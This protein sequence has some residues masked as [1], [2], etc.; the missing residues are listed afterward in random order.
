M[1]GF[2]GSRGR[3]ESPRI[4][5]DLFSFDERNDS[6]SNIRKRTP[7]KFV[8]HLNDL[9]QCF[10]TVYFTTDNAGA[11]NSVGPEKHSE[12]VPPITGELKHSAFGARGSSIALL[13]GKETWNVSK[14]LLRSP[15]QKGRAS[16]SLLHSSWART[17][18]RRCGPATARRGHILPAVFPP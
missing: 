5:H 6:R 1:P 11:G 7:D 16:G 3:V 18:I 12:G 8:P 17:S 4:C 13:Q 2:A 15:P 10:S 9:A 14:S